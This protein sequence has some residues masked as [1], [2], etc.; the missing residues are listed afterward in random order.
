MACL[1]SC[2]DDTAS[3]EA[4]GVSLTTFFP[5]A[6]MQGQEM[7]VTGTRLGEAK[8]FTFP[9][10]VE[11]SQFELVSENMI[12]MTVPT[13]ISSED[14]ELVMNLTDGSSLISRQTMHRAQPAISGMEPGDAVSIMQTLTVNGK[15]MQSIRRV[16]MPY[17]K[18][19]TQTIA[20]EAMEFM[21]KSDDNIQFTVPDSVA[22]GDVSFTLEAYDGTLLRTDPIIVNGGIGGLAVLWK[23]NSPTEQNWDWN[24]RALVSAE[25]VA[26]IK[27][28]DFL[29]FDFVAVND[30]AYM[31]FSDLDGNVIE[32][33]DFEAGST[34]GFHPARHDNRLL[35][36]TDLARKLSHG[37]GVY[38]AGYTLRSIRLVL[39]QE[40]VGDQPVELWYTTTPVSQDWDFGKRASVTA[41]KL[42]T[43]T[44]GDVI[45]FSM[46]GSDDCYMYWK[47]LDSWT[48]IDYIFELDAEVGAWHPMRMG[49]KVVV[50]EK[51][52]E[53]LHNGFSVYGWGYQLTSITLTQ[54]NPEDAPD[55]IKIPD[56][57]LETIGTT[58]WSNT[59][60]KAQNWDWGNRAE[61]TADQL[62][63]LS[64]GD[65]LKYQLSVDNDGWLYF[66]DLDGNAIQSSD[67]EPE[68]SDKSG[69]HPGRHD[70]KLVVTA[71]IAAK[72]RNGFATYGGSCT[73]ARIA[74][75]ESEDV[76]E[77]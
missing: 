30:D 56:V 77:N 71:D 7:T 5:T 12:R 74:L 52:V 67:F 58:L 33:N 21:R 10:G 4:R 38:G 23:T 70:Y 11:V 25:K 3:E 66:R 13:G 1:V 73:L 49:C 54:G 34:S 59:Q 31:A 39:S 9:G 24:A 62:T 57:E 32:S 60:P 65:I 2:S 26:N 29:E 76:G 63:T 69:W 6:V 15:D 20:V 22:G 35:I 64:E 51:L 27:M 19:T 44:P 16:Y 43:L 46:T 48:G 14:G 72:L 50:T 68:D 42:L 47:Q 40:P 8:T 37:F 36:T 75:I 53:Q 45:E 41:D 18:D 61:V 55:D 17:G 28:G